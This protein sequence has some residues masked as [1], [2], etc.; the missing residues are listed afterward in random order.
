[1]RLRAKRDRG[2][3][4]LDGRVAGA[5]I[6]RSGALVEL[7]RRDG[8]RWRGVGALRTGPSGRFTARLTTAGT[9]RLHLRALVPAQPGLPFAAGRSR[10]VRV[11]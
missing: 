2:A 9:G 10:V 11:G 7:Q 5:R 1:V 6:P 8:R 4:R 3:V